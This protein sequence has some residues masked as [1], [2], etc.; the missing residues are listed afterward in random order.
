MTIS[1]DPSVLVSWYSARAGVSSGGAASSG[2]TTSTAPKPPWQTATASTTSKASA[3]QQKAAAD[4]QAT[5]FANSILNGQPL[6][7]L[8]TAKLS[9]N[10]TDPKVN[11]DYK[12]LF[13][14]YQGVSA[15]QSIA[16]QAGSASTSQLTNYQKAFAS[17]L[18]QLQTYLGKNP[19]QQ[20]SIAMGAVTSRDTS[21]ASVPTE[22]DTYQGAAIYSGDLSAAVPSL[23]N[24]PAN[25]ASGTST[26]GASGSQ[27]GSSG[28]NLNV[29]ASDG[30]TS[31][32]HVDLSSLGSLQT[33]LTSVVSYVLQH[34]QTQDLSTTLSDIL[35]A[36]SN[37]AS[38]SGGTSSSGGTSTVPSNT[39]FSATV[40]LASG[41]STTVSF[42]LNDMGST[43]RTLPNV[44]TYMNSKLK[45]AGLKTTI[46]DVRI[47]GVAKTVTSGKTTY[48]L[49]APA[50][51]FAL[52][53]VG[54]P[55]ETLTFSAPSTQ[56]AVY[57]SQTSGSTTPTQ[58]V[59]NNKVVSTPPT[60]SFWVVIRFI[61]NDC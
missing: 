39:A 49:P 11:S 12:N 25:T 43:P 46:Q 19:F 6:I 45:A 2:T 1:F 58:T 57:V 32:L 22:T 41:S 47:P 5:A 60:N 15:L 61:D 42:D 24:I 7:N 51:S 35:T 30:T 27:T 17:D 20:L 9:A 50:D 44:V 54:T 53:I 33:S 38:N 36:F 40:K 48:T 16:T 4:A 31:T 14:L 28:F 26:G 18:S 34:V 8:T 23:T 59:V 3:D 10:G 56:P 21:A 55:N 29:K 37:M 52:K 13:A